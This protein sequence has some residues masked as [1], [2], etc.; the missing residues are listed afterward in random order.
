MRIQNIDVSRYS[1]GLRTRLMSS[2][3]ADSSYTND[4]L[5]NA[6]AEVFSQ[7][8]AN[9]VNQLNTVLDS[10]SVL[11]A[12]G[13]ALDSLAASMYGIRRKPA[14]KASSTL[15][16]YNVYFTVSTGR[17]DF[18][19][20]NNGNSITIPAGTIISSNGSINSAG[21]INYLVSED[22][23]LLPNSRVTYVSVIALSSGAASNVNRGTL[24]YHNFTNYAEADSNTLI[25]NNTYPILSGSNSESDDNFRFR[26][27]NY[28]NSL[29]QVNYNNI[30]FEN[31]MVPG[32]I[33]TKVINSY[34]GI[35]TAA[36]V[37]FA[38][39]KESNTQIVSRVQQILNSKFSNNFK[40][41]AIE[42]RRLNLEIKI[43]V[44]L[45]RID[46][47]DQKKNEINKRVQD[48]T[49][50]YFND[51]I[52]ENQYILADYHNTMIQ[53]ISNS[54]STPLVP[55]TDYIPVIEANKKSN[56][57]VV[58]NY[59]LTRIESDIFLGDDEMVEIAKINLE[60][61]I[62]D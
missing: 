24:I 23:I 1:S 3:G 7:E 15:G 34:F 13:D 49:L 39:A 50:T 26:I 22:A 20:I 44:R 6:V 30:L 11:N 55:S 41:I 58:E 38:Q 14:R 4:S 56:N 27:T 61:V 40:F 9:Y 10:M 46:N 57:L 16:E 37:C 48:L 8:S 53:E 42:P 12:K 28:I 47:T 5:I 32:I 19:S 62:K 51:R 33:D 2:L 52:G 54:L 36:V 18:G 35:G 43:K 29:K 25:V 31:F 21:A 17:S 45:N 60:F 59:S